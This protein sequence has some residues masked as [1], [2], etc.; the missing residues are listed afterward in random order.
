MGLWV[1]NPRADRIR[2]IVETAGMRARG[3]VEVRGD[4]GGA[5]FVAVAVEVFAEGDD[6]V[7]DR[8][9]RCG[10]GCGGVGVNAG[11]RPGSPSARNRCTR[12]ITQR[13]ETP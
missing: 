12:V 8:L 2:Q 13:R 11:A 4:G 5:G 7:L 6:L 9:R 1:T 10:R 3:V